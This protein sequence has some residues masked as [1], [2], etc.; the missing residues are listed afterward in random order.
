MNPC[1][2]TTIVLGAGSA[3]EIGAPTTKA[4]TDEIRKENKY[5]NYL[6][7][8]ES[9]NIEHFTAV[10]KIYEHL[11]VKYPAEP[12]F[13]H[14]Y[15]VLEMLYS[16]Y[17]VWGNTIKNPDIYSV[18][19][20]F[21]EP[22]KGVIDEKESCNLSSL[23]KQCQLH[24]MDLINRYDKDF[25]NNIK[26]HSWYMDFWRS[27][28]GFDLF[29]FNYDTTIE[30][31]LD[32]YNDGFVESDDVRF[33][34][35]DPR[36]LLDNNCAYKICH[37][38]GCIVYFDERYNDPNHDVYNYNSYDLYKWSDYDEV[39]KVST[40]YLHSNPSSQGGESLFIGPIITGLRKTEKLT[41]SPYNYYHH[42]LNSAI[43]NNH[44]LLIVGYSFGDLYVNDLFE[45]MNLLHGNKKRIVVI[46]Y[47]EY[48][49]FKESDESITKTF[50]G[51]EHDLDSINH[52]ELIFLKKMMEDDNF[53]F[54]ELDATI[55]KESSYTSKNGQ[56]KL[57]VYGF[58]SAVT[59]HKNEIFDFLNE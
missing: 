50:H 7:H 25:Q 1:H 6:I 42:Y 59:R 39:K 26:N 18:I 31:C 38:H 20:P 22:V 30:H 2:H 48:V 16:Y 3:I 49:S 55:D 23:I 13:E 53:E 58:K 40:G 5:E 32:T 35:F 56:V 4:I 57:F 45:R 47:I 33:K 11:K 41:V 28:G 12:N 51:K 9:D 43:I 46:T 24:I 10:N 27:F 29:N 15:H 8:P 14:I 19:A 37:L 52:R 54:R 34:R 36:K 44:S 21:I 17:W